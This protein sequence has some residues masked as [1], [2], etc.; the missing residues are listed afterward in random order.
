M[1]LEQLAINWQLLGDF[2]DYLAINSKKWLKM[3]NNGLMMFCYKTPKG[4]Q[5]RDKGDIEAQNEKK[6]SKFNENLHFYN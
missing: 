1:C 3:A 4:I 5:R 6:G 2:G